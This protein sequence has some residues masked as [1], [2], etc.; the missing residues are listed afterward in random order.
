MP[1]DVFIDALVLLRRT[2]GAFEPA[3]RRQLGV[4]LAGGATAASDHVG[5]DL[6]AERVRAGLHTVAA[7][8]RPAGARLRER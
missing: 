8:A 7:A 2:F 5:D 1:G 4:L 6:D 3:E